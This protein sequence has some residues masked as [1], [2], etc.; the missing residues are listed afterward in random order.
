MREAGNRLTEALESLA[1]SFTDL[2]VVRAAYDFT[3]ARESSRKKIEELRTNC[4][5]AAKNFGIDLK[6]TSSKYDGARARI[7]EIEQQYEKALNE[8]RENYVAECEENT[9]NI[10]ACQG[11]KAGYLETLKDA[12]KAKKMYLRK[13]APDIAEELEP[14]DDEI[15]D[16]ET[17]MLQAC[18]EH[19]YDRV[20][21]LSEKCEKA[22][23]KKAEIESKLTGEHKDKL[24]EYDSLIAGAKA[25]HESCIATMKGYKDLSKVM[26]K[27]FEENCS[28][29][30]VERTDSLA[31][32]ENNK[33][34]DKI[35]GFFAK[36]AIGSAN[37]VKNF[38]KN[39]IEPLSKQVS[40]FVKGVPDMIKSTREKFEQGIEDALDKGDK[41]LDNF[42]EI[43]GELS[44][45]G[46]GILRG[47]GNLAKDVGTGIVTKTEEIVT[48]IGTGVGNAALATGR[49]VVKASKAVGD[50]TLKAGK[51]VADV[52]RAAVGAGKNAVTATMNAGKT[53]AVGVRDFIGSA[54]AYGKRGIENGIGDIKNGIASGLDEFATVLEQKAAA[55]RDKAQKIR[56]ELE[57]KNKKDNDGPEN[58]EME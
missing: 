45:K 14:Y 11:A 44:D 13:E 8:L 54:Y 31:K 41:A 33:F 42:I 27:E 19:D 34:L 53:A 23:A 56:K 47:V 28:A 51:A 30:K 18:K 3:N 1:K 7:K 39:F 37:K 9:A 17:Q 43:V 40:G 57:D 24:E 35:K 46:K 15:A 6:D 10:A 20:K 12:K 38:E 22:E 52:G 36:N 50:A 2:A 25:G 16:F 4:E 55:N 21:E 48:G 5:N 32:V 26:K 49:T 58:G 29:L